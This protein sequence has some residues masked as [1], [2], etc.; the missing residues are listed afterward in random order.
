MLQYSRGNWGTGF[1]SHAA[2]SSAMSTACKSSNAAFQSTCSQDAVVLHTVRLRSNLK[3][4]FFTLFINII[5]SI[6]HF[7]AGQL[8]LASCE[9]IWGI[10]VNGDRYK[11]K[12]LQLLSWLT[13]IYTHTRKPPVIWRHTNYAKQIHQAKQSQSSSSGIQGNVYFWCT[14]PHS[15]YSNLHYLQGG[16]KHRVQS[17]WGTQM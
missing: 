11:H 10:R 6:Q 12:T 5:R 14:A 8:S 7:N 4:L 15:K 17:A 9:S 16:R 1:K 3:I 13:Q 2:K